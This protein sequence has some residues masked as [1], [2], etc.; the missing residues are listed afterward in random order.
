MKKQSHTQSRGR[1]PRIEWV[2]ELL[3][4]IVRYYGPLDM[5]PRK[6][7]NHI[8]AVH[9]ICRLL[10]A[11]YDS[12]P[13]QCIPID[14]LFDI[15][16]KLI[17][18]MHG[19]NF[20]PGSIR[21]YV[22]LKDQL[23]RYA[24]KFNWNTR[25]AK[26]IR[27]WTPIR[28]ALPGKT[29]QGPRIVIHAIKKGRFPRNYGLK[30]IEIFREDMD[31]AGLSVLTVDQQVAEIRR[32]VQ[33]A[34]LSRYLPRLAFVAGRQPHYALP[35]DKLPAR[36]VRQIRTIVNSMR[37]D[38]TLRESSARELLSALRQLCSYAIV[39]RRMRRI[40]DLRQVITVKV[41]C[42]WIDFL[43]HT[44]KCRPR[45][46]DTQLGRICAM[47][48]RQRKLA[49]VHQQFR[50]RLNSLP[51]ERRWV[52]RER[53]RQKLVHPDLLAEV[54]DKLRAERMN[55]PLLS[56]MHQARLMHDELF[57]RWMPVRL[58]NQAGCSLNPGATITIIKQEIT[59]SF[60]ARIRHF[61]SD[62]EKAWSKNRRRQFWI[63]RIFETASKNNDEI[64]EVL[65]L[66]VA[67]LLVKFRQV[68]H[69][70]MNGKSHQ[71]LFLNQKGGK[72]KPGAVRNL[73][74]RITSKYL[75]RP[76]SHH[77]RRDC[78][79]IAAI[80]AGA[81]IQEVGDRLAQRSIRST[82]DYLAGLD[83]SGATGLLEKHFAEAGLKAV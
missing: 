63:C 59:N 19:L 41:I 38:G 13:L 77:R 67:S 29:I 30:D 31:A 49:P 22:S 43:R 40:K 50:L 16:E 24:L 52:A 21:W 57:F 69:L 27:A 55:N 12:R 48:R 4:A 65:P 46:I 80:L 74:K 1:L 36:V 56:P 47:A 28:N 51:K 60:K 20:A 37:N 72:L 64:I 70:L 25:L 15:D 53:K 68:R 10:S 6:V 11:I 76:L 71:N 45:S 5:Q 79:A 32:A 83:F 44:R 18:H 61:P 3:D 58:S 17:S 66:K 73:M 54:P 8:N 14:D 78:A 9:R 75:P 2:S 35:W 39:Y 42:D 26:L 62:V 82:I 81:T 23:I 33:R 7:R 34:K